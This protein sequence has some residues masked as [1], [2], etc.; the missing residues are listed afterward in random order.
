MQDV[1]FL[2]VTLAFFALTWALVVFASR[3]EEGDEK[4]GK[5]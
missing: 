2:L 5:P 3:L 1:L 4:A